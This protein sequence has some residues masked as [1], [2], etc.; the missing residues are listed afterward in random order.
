MW[1]VSDIKSAALL[2]GPGNDALTG[3]AN[4][5]FPPGANDLKRAMGVQVNLLRGHAAAY[6]AIAA[7]VRDQLGGLR[8]G[9]PVAAAQDHQP[10]GATRLRPTMPAISG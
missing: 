2:G 3:Y 1:A 10:A 6:R 7:K 4:G 8:A 5:A 9:R